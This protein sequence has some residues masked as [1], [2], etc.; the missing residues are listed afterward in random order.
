MGP[1]QCARRRHPRQSQPPQRLTNFEPVGEGRTRVT[2]WVDMHD[3]G[4]SMADTV[5]P[6]G[7]HGEI[8]R[9][10]DEDNW[11]RSQPEAALA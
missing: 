11:A 2:I 8:G 3:L 10:L 1:G 7:V 6:I 9:L 4:D 5:R